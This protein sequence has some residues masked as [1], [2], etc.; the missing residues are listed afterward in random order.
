MTN[1]PPRL[2]RGLLALVVPKAHREFVSGDLAEAFEE[3]AGRDGIRR[4]RRWYWREVLAAVITRWPRSSAPFNPHTGRD[5]VVQTFWQDLKFGMRLL[6]RSPGFAVVSI[7]TLGLGIGANTTVFSWINSVLLSPIPGAVAQHRL[8]EVSTTYRNQSISMSYPDYVDYRARTRLLSGIAARDDQAVHVTVGDVT[9]RVWSEIVTGNYFDVLGVRAIVGR[10]FLPHEDRIPGAAPVAVISHRL[11]QSRFGSDPGVLHQRVR[12][13]GHPFTIVG[14]APAKFQGSATA[15]AYDMWIP[16]MM[17]PTLMPSGD[18]LKERDSHW[19]IAF[20]RLAPGVTLEQADDEL[21]A[22]AR[23]LAAEFPEDRELG[24]AIAYLRE[25]KAGAIGVLRPV[26]L[27]LGVVTAIVLLI[28]CANLANLTI[29]RGAA[30]RREI[31]IR[32][33]IGARRWRVVRQL[34]TESVLIAL[35]GAGLALVIARWTSQLLVF[36]AP[37]TEFTILIDVPLDIRVFAFTGAAGLLTALLFGLVPALQ[38]SAADHTTALKDDSNATVSGRRWLRDALVVAEVALSLALLVSA[39]LCV[40]SMQKAQ[41]FDPGFNSRGVLLTAVDLFPAGYSPETGRVFYRTLLERLRALPAADSVTVSRRVPLGFGGSSASTIEVDGYAPKN[42]ESMSVMFNQVGPDYF[43]TM[44]IPLMLGRD[45]QLNDDE[46]SQPAAVI[47]ETMARRYWGDR[48]PIGGRFRFGS[49]APWTTVVGVAREVKFR[50]LADV[51]RPFAYLPVLQAYH[52][53][54]TI[55]VR[56]AGDPVSVAPA[57]REVVQSLDPA[58]PVFAARTLEAHTGAATFQQRMAGSLLSVF[59]ALAVLLAAVGLYGVLAFLVGQR[60]REIGV[61]VALGA[62]PSSVFR[63]VARHG[64]ALT[65]VGTVIGFLLAFG[66][67][68]ALSAVLFGVTAYDAPTIAV[69]LA[70]LGMCAAAAC[71]IP[72]VRASRVDPVKALKYE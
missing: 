50:S 38:S 25:S 41:R 13:N 46:G 67:A 19:M 21:N 23:Q 65:T 42:D 33:S 39:G 70:V 72:A 35:G 10:T 31:A 34:L 69:A 43:R 55:H 40:R 12:I 27:A 51:P 17:Q 48:N 6:R 49:D 53:A 37:P 22:I 71:T 32:L 3:I 16:M 57:V 30:R 66:I 2:A 61:R 68:Q 36:F 64:L 8:V 15:V 26:L 28:A 62:T 20:A 29:A 52:P 63:L 5:S 58:L 56:T 44:Q 9:E 4:A 14:V 11:W 18:R 45:I 24:V 47:N 60:R 59:G 7:L 1:G 54:M